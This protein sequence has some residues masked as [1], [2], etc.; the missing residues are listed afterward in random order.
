MRKSISNRRFIS[1]FVFPALA[2]LAPG[3]AD[4]QLPPSKYVGSSRERMENPLGY[5]K[6]VKG[7]EDA[8]SDHIK[9]L[10]AKQ[11]AEYERRKA[12]SDPRDLARQKIQT[13]Q[14]EQK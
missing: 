11:K 6:K 4:E 13:E 1:L 8:K 9:K 7:I 10:T 5:A 14:K 3:C 2:M 12:A